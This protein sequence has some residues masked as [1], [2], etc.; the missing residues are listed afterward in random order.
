MNIF[1][2]IL[3]DNH[4]ENL[5]LLSSVQEFIEIEAASGLLGMFIQSIKFYTFHF[6]LLKSTD[7]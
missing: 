7:V 3:S 5:C 1:N 6:H 2:K 4:S